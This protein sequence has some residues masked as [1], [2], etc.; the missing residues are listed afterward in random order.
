MESIDALRRLDEGAADGMSDCR[1]L[2]VGGSWVI[3]EYD[4]EVAGR[5]GRL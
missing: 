1:R 5:L 4:G 2:A 3:G